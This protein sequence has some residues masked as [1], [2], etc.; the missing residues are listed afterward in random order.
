MNRNNVI[1]HDEQS[2]ENERARALVFHGQMENVD[3]H[4]LLLHYIGINDL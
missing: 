1:C 4:S 3:L 2:A